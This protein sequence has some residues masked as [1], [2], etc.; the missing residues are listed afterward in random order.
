[1]ALL[2]LGVVTPQNI[3]NAAVEE[4]KLQGF[5]NPDKYWT[6]PTKQPPQPPNDQS[7]ESDNGES[8]APSPAPNLKGFQSYIPL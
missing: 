6:D 2:P 4:V 3:Y 5:S 7:E 1:M 8:G